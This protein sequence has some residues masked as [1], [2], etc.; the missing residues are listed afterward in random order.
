[1][2]RRGRPRSKEK[3]VT[4]HVTMPERL[5]KG[6]WMVAAKKFSKPGRTAHLIIREAVEQYIQKELG[7][8]S[9]PS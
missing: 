3:Y 5:Y 8:T 1:M 4:V 9:S 2:G 7:Q 6:I